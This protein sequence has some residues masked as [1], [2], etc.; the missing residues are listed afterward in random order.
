MNTLQ[1]GTLEGFKVRLRS[2]RKSTDFD[3]AFRWMQDPEVLRLIGTSW[4]VSEQAEERYFQ[5]RGKDPTNISFA[6]ETLNG[7]HIGNMGLH[8]IDLETQTAE[9]GTLIGEKDYWEKGYGTDA[10]MLLLS[11]AFYHKALRRIESRVVEYNE[12]S[13]RYSLR[14]GYTVE[15]ILRKAVWRDGEWRDIILLSILKPEFLALWERYS[16]TGSVV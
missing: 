1:L 6:I 10:K 8:K 12:R 13:K 11:Y 9:T 16:K 5:D 15:G 4:P 2:P 3:N 14:C 7:K